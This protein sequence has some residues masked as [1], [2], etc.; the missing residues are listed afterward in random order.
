MT[1]PKCLHKFN[2]ICFYTHTHTWNSYSINRQWCKAV[3]KHAFVTKNRTKH[4]Y[5]VT[6][7][8]FFFFS[9]FFFEHELDIPLF[10]NV[11][12]FKAF[13]VKSWWTGRNPRM[14]YRVDHWG[15][16]RGERRSGT[17]R[18]SWSITLPHKLIDSKDRSWGRLEFLLMAASCT[19]S[20]RRSRGFQVALQ[21]SNC[22]FVQRAKVKVKGCVCDVKMSSFFNEVYN[23]DK[24]KTQNYY[25]L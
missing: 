23:L 20:S 5:A 16:R 12:L 6:I 25:S 19:G 14:M 7:C 18:W 2:I 8:T 21:L 15:T 3:L 11:G 9:F 22:G 4:S 10:G 1:V 24:K 13:Q 17:S